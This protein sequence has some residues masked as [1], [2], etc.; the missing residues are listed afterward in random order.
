MITKTTAAT[1]KAPAAKSGNPRADRVVAAAKVEK[2]VT[3][4]TKE[5]AKRSTATPATKAAP[6]TKLPAGFAVKYR[7]G[8][9]DLAKNSTTVGPKWLVICTAHGTTT[10]ADAA[11]LGD[12][13]G[14]RAARAAWCGKC[15][16]SA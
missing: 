3:A 12:A 7:N 2:A 9:Y 13:L 14:R 15:A 8:A 4:A 10:P 16:A 1:K 6:A 11:K 5:A